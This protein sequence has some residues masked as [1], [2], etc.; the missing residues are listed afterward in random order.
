MVI[1][2]IKH[3]FNMKG[4]PLQMELIMSQDAYDTADK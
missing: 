1:F 3:T 4:S 2:L